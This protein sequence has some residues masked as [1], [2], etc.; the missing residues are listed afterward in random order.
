MH[1]DPARPLVHF[2]EKVHAPVPEGQKRAHP[3]PAAHA[4]PCPCCRLSAWLN[5]LQC[6]YNCFYVFA[7]ANTYATPGAI[8]TPF[9]LALHDDRRSV[10][11]K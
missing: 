7:C 5:N 3:P 8:S 9:S 4:A 1:K 11:S 2:K 10:I 6:H